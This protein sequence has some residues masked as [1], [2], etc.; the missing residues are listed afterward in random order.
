MESSERKR[1]IC[2]N[3]FETGTRTGLEAIE[4][5]SR[6]RGETSKLQCRIGGFGET[7]EMSNRMSLELEGQTTRRNSKSRK[8]Y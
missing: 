2:C 5:I 6:R 3:V 1:K 4:R 8:G 7:T